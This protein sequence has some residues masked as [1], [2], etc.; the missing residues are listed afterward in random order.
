MLQERLKFG[1]LGWNVQYQFSLPDFVISVRQLQMFLNEFQDDVPLKVSSPCCCLPQ[2]QALHA[3]LACYM[4][5]MLHHLAWLQQYQGE[6]QEVCSSSCALQGIH[7]SLEL[8]SSKHDVTTAYI[9][10]GSLLLSFS[11]VPV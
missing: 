8:A 9:I 4:H 6:A 10:V 2:G 11:A 7:K 5:H 3:C 1:P